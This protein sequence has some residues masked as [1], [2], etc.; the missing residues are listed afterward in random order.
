MKPGATTRPLAS[1]VCLPCNAALLIA[2]ILPPL[3]PTLRTASIL[4]S[5]SITLPFVIAT[6]YDTSCAQSDLAP[7]NAQT[8]AATPK[9][10]SSILFVLRS[11]RSAITVHHPLGSSRQVSSRSR[12]VS[13]DFQ[14][15]ACYSGF[16]PASKVLGRF[17]Q[18]VRK[19]EIP[20]RLVSKSVS[21]IT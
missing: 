6:S 10:A 15:E 5:G 16:R 12:E 17:I 14:V 19:K 18:H 7:L 13:N 4:D 3:I 8:R 2:R 20:R 21:T 9:L 11:R 1:I